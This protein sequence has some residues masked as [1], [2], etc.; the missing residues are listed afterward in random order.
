MTQLVTHFL[1][2]PCRPVQEGDLLSFTVY[3]SQAVDLTTLSQRR[4]YF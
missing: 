2:S 4:T 1:Q 3:C